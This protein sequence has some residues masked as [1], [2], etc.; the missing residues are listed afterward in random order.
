MENDGKQQ[1][2]NETGPLGS[3]G[4]KSEKRLNWPHLVERSFKELQNGK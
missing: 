1:L 2:T 3:E 4:Q